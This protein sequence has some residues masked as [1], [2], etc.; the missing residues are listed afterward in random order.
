MNLKTDPKWT[1]N[2]T[3]NIIHVVYE[4]S[5]L[6]CWLE[7]SSTMVSNCLELTLDPWLFVFADFPNILKALKVIQLK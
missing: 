3:L 7:F 6:E 5:L 2:E 4:C 1:L